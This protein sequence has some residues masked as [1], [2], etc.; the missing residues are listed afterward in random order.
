MPYT[1]GI[2]DGVFR[3]TPPEDGQQPR[4]TKG[5]IDV[6]Y[7]ESLLDGVKP[8][9]GMAGE[10]E[11]STYYFEDPMFEKRVQRVD[12]LKEIERLRE[13]RNRRVSTENGVSVELAIRFLGEYTT[14]A[15]KVA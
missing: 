12:P 8:L 9:V 14:L 3:R 5:G 7:M 4:Y 15:R 2:V 1:Y 13:L 6:L 10:I 11:G